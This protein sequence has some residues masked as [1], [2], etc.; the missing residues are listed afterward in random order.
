[1]MSQLFPA[2]CGRLYVCMCMFFIRSKQLESVCADP[3]LLHTTLYLR[4]LVRCEVSTFSSHLICILRH[5]LSPRRPAPRLLD[6]PP[7]H[8]RALQFRETEHC[9]SWSP[10]GDT[11][12]FCLCASCHSAPGA[13]IPPWLPGCRYNC[14]TDHCA[15]VITP[16]GGEDATLALAACLLWDR[17]HRVSNLGIHPACIPNHCSICL[18]RFVRRQAGVFH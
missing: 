8:Q 2:V 9:H 18:L 15:S 3:G 6:K 11:W 10:S 16:P 5:H 14:R 13:K 12:L 4:V 1:M 17:C 7:A